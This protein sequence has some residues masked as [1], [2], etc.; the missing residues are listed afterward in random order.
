MGAQA[1]TKLILP[2]LSRRAGGLIA[3]DAI[4]VLIDEAA[5]AV[6]P[7]GRGYWLCCFGFDEF[8]LLH[9]QLAGGQTT[10]DADLH[11]ALERACRTQRNVGLFD[12]ESAVHNAVVGRQSHID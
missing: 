2:L 5:P 1:L 4:G 11:C 9:R 7:A 8:C 3:A 6:A 10:L 12:F